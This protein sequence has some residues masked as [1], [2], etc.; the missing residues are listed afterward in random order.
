[1]IR[2]SLAIAAL[3]TITS[4]TATLAHAQEP[5]PTPV[6]VKDYDV[7]VDLPTAFAYIKLPTGW[8]FIGKLDASQLK[9]LPP[10]TLTALLRT[11]AEASP[12]RMAAAGRMV[13]VLK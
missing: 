6:P 10:G 8:K 9:Q 7:Y 11:D 5:V 1:M 13:P 2:R 4:M 12:V 3:L